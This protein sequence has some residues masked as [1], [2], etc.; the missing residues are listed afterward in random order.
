MF[1]QSFECL[2]QMF[3]HILQGSTLFYYASLFFMMLFYAIHK[4]GQCSR[5]CLAR[6]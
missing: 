4:S 1:R 5:F 6:F 2:L 3:F